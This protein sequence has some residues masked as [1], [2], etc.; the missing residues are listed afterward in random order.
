MANNRKLV[1]YPSHF[2]LSHWSYFHHSNFAHLPAAGDSEWAVDGGTLTRAA[3]VGAPIIVITDTNTDN[4]VGGINRPSKSLQFRDDGSFLFRARLSYAE[5]VTTAV[6]NGFIGV[7]DKAITAILGD[8][9][10][11]IAGTHDGAGFYWK[12]GSQTLHAWVGN[13]SEVFDELL[14]ASNRNNLAGALILGSS[15]LVRD[16]QIYGTPAGIGGK[17]TITFKINGFTVAQ[18]SVLTASAALMASHMLV[19]SGDATNEQSMTIYSHIEAQSYANQVGT[20]LA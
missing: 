20:S 2:D 4:A 10:A 17:M 19:K 11:G 13:G 12:E 7:S 8:D 9:G 15:A 6:A 5:A 18:Y 1:E 14:T 16:Y 3:A